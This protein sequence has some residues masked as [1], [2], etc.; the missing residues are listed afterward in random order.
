MIVESYSRRATCFTSCLRKE[1]SSVI[2]AVELN[3]GR[4]FRLVGVGGTF[5]ILHRGHKA[6]LRK[7]LRTGDRVIIGLASDRFVKQMKKRHEVHPL[8][9]RAREIQRFLQH[10]RALR[11]AEIVPIEDQYGPAA[12]S[13]D[14]DALAVSRE[15]LRTGEEINQIRQSSGLPPLELVIVEMVLANDRKPISTGRIREGRITRM[16]KVLKK[17]CAHKA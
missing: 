9:V 8:S 10:E 13:P 4:C 7:A 6:L 11:R 1:M 16:G 14:I 5:D 15:T 12:T 2:E 17:G 3:R